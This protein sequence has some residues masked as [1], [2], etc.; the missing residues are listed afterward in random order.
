[1]DRTI[2]LKLM[3]ATATTTA[4]V[5]GT[6]AGSGGAFGRD[7]LKTPSPRSMIGSLRLIGDATKF[8]SSDRWNSVF[9]KLDSFCS[10]KDDWNSYAAPAPSPL[11][12]AQARTF[13]ECLHAEN[14]E[15]S[16][17]APS[18]IG[19]VGITLR[20]RDRRV[21]VEFRNDGGIYAVQSDQSS[22]PII[23][24]V[25]DDES[26]FRLIIG[27]MKDYLNGATSQHASASQCHATWWVA[28]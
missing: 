21:Y 9:R 3:R 19:G 20:L 10:L 12:I 22:E 8:A 7:Y 2:S 4:L 17:L 23:S 1:M 25:R 15:P 24:A 11:T 27:I 14:L 16:R 18:A 6:T 28:Y 5:V 13:V 26:G